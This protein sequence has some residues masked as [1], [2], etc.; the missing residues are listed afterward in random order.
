MPKS[1]RERNPWETCSF[2][3]FYTQQAAEFALAERGIKGRVVPV[4]LTVTEVLAEE[5]G[6]DFAWRKSRS[7]AQ[8]KAD[9]ERTWQEWQDLTIGS[10][11][12]RIALFQAELEK[13]LKE[14]PPRMCTCKGCG[15]E[16]GRE[17]SGGYC[18]RCSL[19]QL[20]RG[21]GVN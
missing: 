10:L 9:V 15:S 7:D 20:T 3:L 13:V 16:D 14:E 21:E 4:R 17:D 11:R 5:A 19:K 1:W 6:A 2:A 8:Y 18:W 12:K